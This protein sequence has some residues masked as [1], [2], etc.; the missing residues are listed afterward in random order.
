MSTGDSRCPRALHLSLHS[1][2]LSLSP[3]F[4]PGAFITMQLLMLT[5]LN[6]HFTVAHTLLYTAFQASGFY[7][8]PA[9]RT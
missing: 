5:P 6:S 2:F 8:S 1:L 3:L 9:S 7:T 4:A